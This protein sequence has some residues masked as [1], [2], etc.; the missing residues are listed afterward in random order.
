MSGQI[1]EQL[2]GLRIYLVIFKKPLFNECKVVESTEEKIPET[3]CDLRKLFFQAFFLCTCVD[4]LTQ[5]IKC[6]QF[7]PLIDLSEIPIYVLIPLHMEY[8]VSAGPYL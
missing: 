6:I 3:N 1:K 8:A 7:F 2:G 4:T 5:V